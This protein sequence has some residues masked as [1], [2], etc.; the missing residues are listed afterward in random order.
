MRGRSSSTKQIKQLKVRSAVRRSL[1]Q[2]GRLSLVLTFHSIHGE[3]FIR[4]GSAHITK[5]TF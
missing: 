1:A 5:D 4:A 3:M 2:A